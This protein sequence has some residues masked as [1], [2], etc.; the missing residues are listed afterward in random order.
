[1]Q[2]GILGY[3]SLFCENFRSESSRMARSIKRDGPGKMYIFEVEK[4]EFL[5]IIFEKFLKIFENLSKIY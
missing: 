5:G 1:M 3:P 2:R 4:V